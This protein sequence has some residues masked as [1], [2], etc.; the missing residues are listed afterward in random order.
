MGGESEKGAVRDFLP[1]RMSSEK[2]SKRKIA[3]FINLQ[4]QVICFIYLSKQ[5][6]TGTVDCHFQVVLLK[7]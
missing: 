7:P 6:V 5:Q 3:F 4:Y 2:T 1:H